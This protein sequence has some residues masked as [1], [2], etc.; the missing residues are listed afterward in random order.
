MERNTKPLDRSRIMKAAHFTA[1]WRRASG[2][3]RSYRELF[4]VALRAEFERAKAARRMAIVIRE[5]FVAGIPQEPRRRELMTR[6]TGFL[7]AS[8]A[9]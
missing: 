5:R 7:A 2:V 3:Q 6:Q 1:R 8:F 4:V 9:R